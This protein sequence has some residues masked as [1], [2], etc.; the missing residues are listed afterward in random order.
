MTESQTNQRSYEG[1]G[2]FLEENKPFIYYTLSQQG[3]LGT[4][5]KKDGLDVL[6]ECLERLGGSKSPTVGD[7]IFEFRTYGTGRH[8]ETQQLQVLLSNALE[9]QDQPG[10]T[11]STPLDLNVLKKL[12]GMKDGELDPSVR[13]CMM[14]GA[15]DSYKAL[16]S[17]VKQEGFGEIIASAITRLAQS[18]RRNHVGE[19]MLEIILEALPHIGG[20][21]LSD[22]AGYIAL[23]QWG[24]ELCARLNSHPMTPENQS[25]DNAVRNLL[26]IEGKISE[27]VFLRAI[28]SR[29]PS[30]KGGLKTF[31]EELT[32]AM[33]SNV[34]NFLKWEDDDKEQQST[35]TRAGNAF[36]RQSPGWFGQGTFDEKAL[37]HVLGI[38]EDGYSMPKANE[39]KIEAMQIEAMQAKNLGI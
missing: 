11:D 8:N 12:C 1:Y 19:K 15:E 24:R 3:G 20:K 37:L 22:A 35:R 4:I 26:E 18:S 5:K 39:I 6:L 32:S 31:H 13:V 23:P 36:S 9:R 2:E 10:E 17:S 28:Q 30:L 21:S 34:P 14:C 38:P 7:L 25:L 16:L 29:L 27:G 33:G